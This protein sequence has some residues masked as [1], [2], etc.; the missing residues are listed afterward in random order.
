MIPSKRR[1]LA[2]ASGQNRTLGRL[3]S[4]VRVGSN[5]D[6]RHRLALRL[7]CDGEPTFTP[8]RRLGSDTPRR[9]PS[10]AAYNSARLDRRNLQ[11]RGIPSPPPVASVGHHRSRCA[12]MRR[13]RRRSSL[14]TSHE[15]DVAPRRRSWSK[16]AGPSASPT[17]V[18]STRAA[19]RASSLCSF[20]ATYRS[21]AIARR[22][23]SR[24]SSI[25]ARCRNVG[26]WR[27]A[28]RIPQICAFRT[29]NH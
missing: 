3:R 17:A 25:V 19:R 1:R 28:V 11:M 26:G 23:P 20:D 9:Q 10:P 22:K 18:S 13:K 16:V 15:S 29:P 21:M 8:E 27:A 6:L 12:A 14:S 5:C 4:K 24:A 2:S 7:E